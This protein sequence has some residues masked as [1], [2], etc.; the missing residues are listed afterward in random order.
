[1][2]TSISRK[3]VITAFAAATALGLAAC[4]P[5]NEQDSDQ[6]V[7]TATSQD[8]NSL[9]GGGTATGTATATTSAT[10]AAPETETEAEGESE[11]DAAVETVTATEVAPIEEPLDNA[12]QP[13]N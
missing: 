2:S 1:M 4:S 13:Q 10:P 9:P 6:K 12:P 8:P 7:D 3:V 11:A 5:P